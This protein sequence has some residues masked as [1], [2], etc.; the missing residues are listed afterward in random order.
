M[1][2][3]ISY[4]P[5][6]NKPSNIQNLNKGIGSLN[7]KIC[8]NESWNWQN[9]A[10]SVRDQCVYMSSL[11]L[12]TGRAFTS[13]A[14][15]MGSTPH[16]MSR[17]WGHYLQINST[18]EFLHLTFLML[19][20]LFKNTHKPISILKFNHISNLTLAVVGSLCLL[21]LPKPLHLSPKHICSNIKSWFPSGWI[22]WRAVAHTM[23]EWFWLFMFIDPL[24][25]SL[26][27]TQHCL[28]CLRR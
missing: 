6:G 7:A 16:S 13:Y 3:T 27:I 14:Q 25:L 23:M 9:A 15:G 22:T 19:S 8:V 10:L 20:M 12:L 24:P 17:G 26:L 28:L 1:V 21:T 4:C 18:E 2:A 5:K 11:G